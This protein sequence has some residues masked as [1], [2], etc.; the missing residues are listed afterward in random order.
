M[1]LGESLFTFACII[2]I[3]FLGGLLYDFY[4]ACGRVLYIKRRAVFIGDLLFWLLFT[5]AA[6]I[7][8]L[9][10]NQ[11]EVRFYVI[12]GLVLGV[13]F[14]SKLLSRF[15]YLLFYR[16]FTLSVSG[17]RFFVKTFKKIGKIFFL[18]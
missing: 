2:G 18:V 6:L 17:I 13:L 11:G 8:L 14:Y 5:A 12:L 15:F 1:A 9:L 7:L 16:I 3:G 4:R 10:A